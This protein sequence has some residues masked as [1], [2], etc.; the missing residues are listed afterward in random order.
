LR[1]S[2][3]AVIRDARYGV[4]SRDSGK[5]RKRIDGWWHGR[6]Q[7]G[8]RNSVSDGKH[9][10]EQSQTAYQHWLAASTREWRRPVETSVLS[11]IGKADIDS[12]EID[13]RNAKRPRER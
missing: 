11:R 3:D 9:R 8:V 5:G 12:M 4:P 7:F 6:T 1:K 2:L 13:V 10:R